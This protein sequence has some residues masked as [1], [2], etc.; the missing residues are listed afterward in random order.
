MTKEVFYVKSFEE[1][2]VLK[3]IKGTKKFHLKQYKI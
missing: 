3:T 2:F 1:D